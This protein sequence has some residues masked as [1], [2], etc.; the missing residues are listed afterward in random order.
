MISAYPKLMGQNKGSSQRKFIALSYF[1]RKKNKDICWQLKEICWQINGTP[2]KFR[3]ERINNKQK[4]QITR[5]NQLRGEFN[6]ID[7]KK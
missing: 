6:S 4:E 3:T 2:K 7:T 1:H 5:D